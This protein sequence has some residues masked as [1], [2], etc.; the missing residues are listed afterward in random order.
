[1]KKE[2]WIVGGLALL[3]LYGASKTK[4]AVTISQ[5]VTPQ[6]EEVF[7]VETG[8]P[9]PAVEKAYL[10]PVMEDTIIK[11]GQH[12]HVIFEGQRIKINGLDVWASGG[13]PVRTTFESSG[14]PTMVRDYNTNDTQSLHSEPVSSVERVQYDYIL[15]TFVSGATLKVE[16]KR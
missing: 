13:L 6:I 2:Y 12:A 11:A 7:S 15:V 9:E 10:M 3:G 16:V 1:M 14:M 4:D 8:Q 5:A